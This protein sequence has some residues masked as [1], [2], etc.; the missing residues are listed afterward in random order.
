LGLLILAAAED[1]QVGKKRR[2]PGKVKS[3]GPGFISNIKTKL[4]QKV[5]DYQQKVIVFFDDNTEDT[6]MNLDKT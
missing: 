4:G 2:R 5:N 6:D 3:E 1:G